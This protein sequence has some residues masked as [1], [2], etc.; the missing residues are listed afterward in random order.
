MRVVLVIAAWC[1]SA[2]S[3]QDWTPQQRQVIDVVASCNDGWSRSLREKD[4]GVF[5]EA[6]P[7]TPK[8]VF[9]YTVGPT[10][11][12]YGGDEGMWQG[13]AANGAQAS[14]GTCSCSMARTSSVPSQRGLA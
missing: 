8:A 13:A 10:P 2:A 14:G 4:Y 5:A 3:A 6:C 7:Q 9:W 1:V 11:V 12:R